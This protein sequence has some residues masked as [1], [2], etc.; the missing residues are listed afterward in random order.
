ML[1]RNMMVGSV[2]DFVE[3]Y[4][5]GNFV[6]A[7]SNYA[8]EGQVVTLKRVIRGRGD[9]LSSLVNDE[10]PGH[11]TRTETLQCSVLGGDKHGVLI[12]RFTIELKDGSIEEGTAVLFF[13]YNEEDDVAEII[14]DVTLMDETETA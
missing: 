5:R 12:E 8:R 11:I 3:D 7:C 13:E 2:A 14:F 1:T 10:D 9:I 6:T 4:N